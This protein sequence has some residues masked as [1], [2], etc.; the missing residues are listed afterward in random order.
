M[1]YATLAQVKAELKAVTSA[2]SVSEDAYLL[3]VLNIVTARIRSVVQVDFEPTFRTAYYNTFPEH[4]NTLHNTIEIPD[5]LLR[6]TSITLHDEVLVWDDDVRGWPRGKTPYRRLR[7]T[8]TTKSWYP[9]SRLYKDAI[10]GLVVTG[11][12]GMSRDYPNA[13]LDS[14]DSVQNNPLSAA[15][16]TVTV[17]DADGADG[18]GRT[19]RFSAGNLIRIEDE[20]C[21]VLA[22]NTTTNVLTVKRGARG[23]T[24]VAHALGKPITVWQPEPEIQRIAARHAGQLYARRGAYQSAEIGDLGT[25]QYPADLSLEIL[26]TLDLYANGGY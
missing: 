4:I 22:A 26:A 19:P 3:A 17:A 2:S 14:A 18:L 10:E 1:T 6:P 25:I 20:C 7:L 23:T 13:W 24:A 9:N 21:E 5:Y 15:S 12:F 16:T 8:S 11:W